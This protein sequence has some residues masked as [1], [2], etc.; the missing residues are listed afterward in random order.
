VIVPRGW[1]PHIYRP[2]KPDRL[3]MTLPY[4]PRNRAW[5]HT[6]LGER[7]QP[8]WDKDQRNWAI[9]RGH[10]TVLVDE[11]L[12]EFGV[13]YASVEFSTTQKCDTRCREAQGDD[14]EC[15]CL[16]EYHGGGLWGG[17]WVQV[18]ETTLIRSE[19]QIRHM[20]LAR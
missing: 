19:T 16:G 18:G 15:S 8:Y 13:V 14:C 4:R 10:F 11:L 7:I 20:R 5:I 3:R 12:D 2:L 1:L 9:A 17:G 6:A